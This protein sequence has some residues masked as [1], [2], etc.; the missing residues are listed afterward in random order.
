[1]GDGHVTSI[2]HNVYSRRAARTAAL[3]LRARL[4]TTSIAL[5][6]YVCLVSS[7]SGCLHPGRAATILADSGP[8]CQLQVVDGAEDQALQGQEGAAQ[9]QALQGQEGAAED[10]A[11]QGQEDASAVGAAAEVRWTTVHGGR[12]WKTPR[13]DAG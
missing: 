9:D 6:S 8:L 10:R 12:N 7:C 13:V 2:I 4:L 1:M 3:K 11:L 5:Q